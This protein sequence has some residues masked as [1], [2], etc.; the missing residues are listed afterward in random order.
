MAQI[1]FE[2]YIFLRFWIVL[3]CKII[4]NKKQQWNDIIWSFLKSQSKS[5]NFFWCFESNWDESSK[6]RHTVTS[7]QFQVCD[8]VFHLTSPGSIFLFLLIHFC[9]MKKDLDN[10]VFHPLNIT[11]QCIASIYEYC[12]SC[13][14]IILDLNPLSSIQAFYRG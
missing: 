2:V 12:W 10:F 3:L 13:V 6:K 11:I 5:S 7:L 4:H 14:F 1:K 9:W 8:H